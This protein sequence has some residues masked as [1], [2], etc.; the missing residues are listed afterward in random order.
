MSKSDNSLFILHTANYIVYILVD[1][2][3][4]IITGSSSKII[5]LMVQGLSARFFLK[6]LGPLQYFLGVEVLPSEDGI[7]LSQRKYIQDLLSECVCWSAI[8]S[9]LP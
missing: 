7:L 4:I 8:E 1:V 3:D 2:N 6:D 5:S 9:P